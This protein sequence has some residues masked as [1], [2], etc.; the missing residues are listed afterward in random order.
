[1]KQRNNL[2]GIYCLLLFS[3]SSVATAQQTVTT[4]LTFK[5]YIGYVKK[6]H[7][8]VKQAGL[9]ID[10]G[11]AKLMKARGL[12][13]PKVEVDYRKKEFKNTEYYDALNTTFKIPT[14]YGIEVKGGFEQNS[15]AF[16]NPE[17]SV[18]NTGLY[19]AGVSL[20][21]GQGFLINKRMAAIKQAKLYKK[22][23]IAD[24][25]LLVNKVLSDASLAYFDWIKNYNEVKVYKDFLENAKF[26]LEGVKKNILNGEKAAIDSTES[27]ISVY[28]RKLDLI[29]ATIKLKQ[30]RLALSNFIWTNTMIPLELQSTIIPESNIDANIDNVLNLG[31]LEDAIRLESHP[32]L[33]SLDYKYQ[34]LKIDR[35]LKRNKLLPKVDLQYNFLSESIQQLRSFSNTA[36]KGNLLIK[37]PLFL[38]KERG[39]LKFAKLKL[40]SI[41]YEIELT[42][43][44]LKNKIEGIVSE[45]DSFNNQNNITQNIV[46]AYQKMLTAEERKFNIGESSLFLVNSRESKLIDAKLKALSLQNTFYKTK[47]KLFLILS[48]S[49]N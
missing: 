16:L 36:Y 25:T 31:K 45:L 6:F 39:D 3:F 37:F 13:D 46:I 30:S 2:F 42:R 11:Q 43:I 40:Q 41:Q 48:N 28:N 32:K 19:S 38:R 47:A 49:V 7:P 44:E 12:F 29:K 23:A 4:V 10:E 15:G 24:R 20:S 14:W 5:E 17:L 21:L 33:V 26:R 34:Q 27:S 35:N 8:L 22:Q 9:I 18:P 1:M